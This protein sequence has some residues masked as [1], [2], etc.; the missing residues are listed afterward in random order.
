MRNFIA[1]VSQD[2][3]PV[4]QVGWSTSL[5][6]NLKITATRNSVSQDNID[7]KKPI[8]PHLVYHFFLP[9]LGPHL[10]TCKAIPFRS[11]S[12]LFEKFRHVCLFSGNSSI[13]LS[14]RTAASHAQ[15]WL[16]LAW[17]WVNNSVSSR[18][19]NNRR[20]QQQWDDTHQNKCGR[21]NMTQYA[22]G[23]FFLQFMM[24]NLIK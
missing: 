4:E 15:P 21:I 18:I 12:I 5:V 2:S 3:A 17:S 24:F 1:E 20:F 22:N 23:D 8:I 11:F 10:Y 6:Y 9:H 7:A 13:K 19:W 16:L 14:R